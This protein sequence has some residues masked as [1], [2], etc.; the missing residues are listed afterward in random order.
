MGLIRKKGD[1]NFVWLF[2]VIA[3]TAILLL[4]VYGAVRYGKTTAYTQDTEIAKSLS[5]VTDS[6]QAG[7]ASGRLSTIRFKKDTLIENDCFLGSFGYNEISVMTQERPNENFES[8]GVPIEVLNKYLFISDKPGKEFYVFSVPI[9]FAFKIADAIIIDSQEYCFLGLENEE[10]IA[11]TLSVIGKKAH[12]GSDNCTEDS[13][14]VCFGTNAGCDVVITPTCRGLS[15]ES[16]YDTGRVSKNRETMEYVGNLLYPAIF[17]EKESYFCNV[18]RIL[19][20]QSILANMYSQKA[21][22]MSA[23]NCNVDLALDLKNLE[24]SSFD[25]SS[26]FFEGELNVIYDYAINIKEKENRGQCK[27]WS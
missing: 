4:A 26:N 23:R 16:E 21:Y 3:G 9:G 17:S 27:L 11:R 5:V 24:E 7:F 22:F 10:N 12:M 8:L 2:A 18:Q 15:C 25:L 1:F 13:I 20:R 6:M 14:T 19:Y